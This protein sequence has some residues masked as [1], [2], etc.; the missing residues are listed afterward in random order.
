[1]L[2]FAQM[3]ADEGMWLMML[4]KRLNGKDLKQG[5]TLL[6]KKFIL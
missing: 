5:L 2:S 3:R 1:M 4:V 6:Q